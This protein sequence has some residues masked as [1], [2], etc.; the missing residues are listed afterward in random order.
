MITTLWLTTLMTLAWQQPSADSVVFHVAPASRLEVRTGKAGL[1]GFA[2]HE[3]VILAREFSGRVVLYRD[4][5]A[6][7]HVAITI[8]TS[9]LEVLT[10][11]DSAEIRKVTAAM[12]T[13]VLDVA[14]YP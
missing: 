8:V 12:R 9:G 7:S 10:P 3:H 1:L 4:Q 13:E 11:P 2:G 5:P 6:R 14:S